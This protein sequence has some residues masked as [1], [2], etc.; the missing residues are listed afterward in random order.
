M[1]DEFLSSYFCNDPQKQSDLMQLV[2]SEFLTF[3]IKRQAFD[4]IIDKNFTEFRTKNPDFSN[5]INNLM[6]QRN[7]L[8]HWMTDTSEDGIKIF[9]KGELRF[10][11]FKSKSKNSSNFKLYSQDE[12]NVWIKTS[13]DIANILLDFLN[14]NNPSESASGATSETSTGL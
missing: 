4:F 9:E 2:I 14:A 12:V 5:K 8:A 11:R 10:V 7:I 6:K 3:D 1:I 13:N